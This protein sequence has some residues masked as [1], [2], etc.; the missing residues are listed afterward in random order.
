MG[1]GVSAARSQVVIGGGDKKGRLRRLGRIWF[2]FKTPRASIRYATSI[3]LNHLALLEDS[4]LLEPKPAVIGGGGSEFPFVFLVRIDGAEK[5][6]CV[7]YVG[8]GAC[9]PGPAHQRWKLEGNL[10][11]QGIGRRGALYS[12]SS[13]QPPPPATHFHPLTFPFQSVPS[14]KL[15]QPRISPLLVILM[16]LVYLGEPHLSEH[17]LQLATAGSVA[18]RGLTSYTRRNS[19]LRYPRSMRGVPQPDTHRSG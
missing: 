4:F 5:L 17:C 6:R 2:L 3:A 10:W 16:C 9:S 8:L 1:G 13:R 19:D 12:A 11:S 15:P 7:R 14:G 18:S